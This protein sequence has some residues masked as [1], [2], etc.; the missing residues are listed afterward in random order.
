MDLMND[1]FPISSQE[2]GMLCE[3]NYLL[4]NQFIQVTRLYS[5]PFSGTEYSR[6]PV[7]FRNSIPFLTPPDTFEVSGNFVR[8]E[9]K[10]KVI[11]LSSDLIDPL[12]RIHYAGCLYSVPPSYV[13]VYFL[14]CG[15]DQFF[16]EYSYG[17]KS[18]T[19]NFIKPPYLPLIILHTADIRDP[20]GSTCI[21]ELSTKNT[22]SSYFNRDSYSL[23][24]I[25]MLIYHWRITCTDDENSVLIDPNSIFVRAIAEIDMSHIFMS[26]EC[27]T[28][29][30][31]PP[32]DSAM[33][34]YAFYDLI[35]RPAPW[36]GNIPVEEFLTGYTILSL[37]NLIAPFLGF[38]G[39]FK[40]QPNYWI[41]IYTD[42]P[43]PE[44]QP[45]FT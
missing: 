7:F 1:W 10:G 21:D 36:V 37:S 12:G 27:S 24:D 23:Y 14:C 13:N 38:M 16:V 39:A 34:Q 20:S 2:T 22:D 41:T 8:I 11:K 15:L 35:S 26:L 25:L 31:R 5:V 45:D 32:H 18:G 43:D 40:P 3:S 30:P 29:L 28:C 4:L 42:T 44:N 6:I 33:N 17:N 9:W 19:M